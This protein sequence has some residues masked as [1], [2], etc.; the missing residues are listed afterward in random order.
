M[1][2]AQSDSAGFPGANV[3]PSW[4]KITGVGVPEGS[5]GSSNP[6]DRGTV[7]TGHLLE[8]AMCSV[9]PASCL[10]VPFWVQGL[11]DSNPGRWT[12]WDTC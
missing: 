5:S 10:V 11:C 2:G 8:Q 6:E 4:L 3:V 12:G 1:P 9:L 7:T